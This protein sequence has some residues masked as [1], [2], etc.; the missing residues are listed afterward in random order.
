[1]SLSIKLSKK[2]TSPAV[3]DMVEKVFDPDLVGDWIPTKYVKDIFIQLYI[4]TKY[5]VYNPD[6]ISYRIFQS[7]YN[8]ENI[9]KPYIGIH[10]LSKHTLSFYN[11]DDLSYYFKLIKNTKKRFTFFSFTLF[12]SDDTE[13]AGFSAHAISMLYD[14][15]TN[16]EVEFKV[17]KY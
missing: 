4:K 12:E 17:V 15:K 10:D 9:I 5:E 1:M 16:E 3:F 14:K 13:S 2:T 8:N 11:K 7:D 6:L